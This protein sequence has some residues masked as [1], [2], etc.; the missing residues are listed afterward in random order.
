MSDVCASS[1]VVD[2][3]INFHNNGFE[4]NKNFRRRICRVETSVAIRTSYPNYVFSTCYHKQIAAYTLHATHN[5]L[6][7]YLDVTE[8]IAKFDKMKDLLINLSGSIYVKTNKLQFQCREDRE[9]TDYFS[10]GN[11]LYAFC[12]NREIQRWFNTLR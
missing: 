10:A 1:V 8:F 3:I 12:N 2:I 5:I 6:W 4:I 9:S 11:E 7:H